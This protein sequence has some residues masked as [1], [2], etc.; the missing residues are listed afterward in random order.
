M[1]PLLLIAAASAWNFN[2][3]QGIA[4]YAVGDFTPGHSH[5]ALYCAES[6][7]K[8]GQ[9]SVILSRAGFTPAAPTPATFTTGGGSVT[10]NLD[11][12]GEI[13]Y[14]SVAAAPRFRELWRL[15]STGKSLTI[16][17]GP[18]APLSF[19]LTGA[20]KLLTSKVCP[21]QLAD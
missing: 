17:Y 8:P 12:K 1:T 18:G 16:A 3:N 2:F 7:M 6:G 5:L 15:L 9:V 13:S 4:E 19:P 21:K 14:A 11:A 10:L 20:G